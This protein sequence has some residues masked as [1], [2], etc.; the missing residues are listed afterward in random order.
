MDRVHAWAAGP[1]FANGETLHQGATYAVLVNKIKLAGACFNL[2]KLARHVARFKIR[3]RLNAL[4]KT[5]VERYTL[6]T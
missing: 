3:C 5:T 1:V 4:K 6:Q 2:K